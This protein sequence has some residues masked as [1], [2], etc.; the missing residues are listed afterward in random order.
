[1]KRKSKQ[2]VKCPEHDQYSRMTR[3]VGRIRGRRGRDDVEGSAN[4][5]Y[6]RLNNT[7]R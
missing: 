6:G 1:M 4:R 5:E 7:M 2:Q 3:E